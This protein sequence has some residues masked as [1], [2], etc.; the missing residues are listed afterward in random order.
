MSSEFLNRSVMFFIVFLLLFNEVQSF[1]Q[2]LY[3]PSDPIWLLDSTNFDQFIL[4]KDHFWVVE[5]YNKWCGH[6]IRF[7]PIWKEFSRS[8]KGWKK[9]VQV[10]AVDC[11]DDI[12]VQLCRNYKVTAYPTIKVFNI[13][14]KNGDP[15]YEIGIE[16]NVTFIKTE[17]INILTNL[18]NENIPS[19]WPSL[20]PVKAKTINQLWQQQPNS[21]TPI[22]L[23]VE[24]PTSTI[25]REIILD[26]SRNNISNVK[27]VLSNQT[28]VEELSHFITITS[29]PML[30]ML[31]NN[32]D[33][34]IFQS[35]NAKVNLREKFLRIL[36]PKL[37]HILP[38]ESTQNTLSS[39][40][41]NVEPSNNVYMVDLENA[42]NYSLRQEVGVHE[43]LKEEKLEALKNFIRILIKYFPGRLSIMRYLNKL[44]LWI[45]EQK[46]EIIVENMMENMILLQ[47]KK[48]YLPPRRDW[49]GCKGSKPSFRGYPCSLWMLFHTLT[50]QAYQ[51]Y[52]KGNENY[53]QEVL[54]AIRGYVK[55][56]FTCADCSEHFQQMASNLENE[57][58][59][60]EDTILWLWRAHNK[61]N[62]RLS[63]DIN[64]NDP[65][66]PKVQFPPLKL[67]P[68]C[69]DKTKQNEDSLQDEK[70][71]SWDILRTLN[72]LI[73]F[74]DKASIKQVK[75]TLHLPTRESRYPIPLKD[76]NALVIDRS[77]MIDS[78]KF[79]Y[80]SGMD[81]SLCV[82]LYIASATLMVILYFLFTLRKRKWKTQKR[83]FVMYP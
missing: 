27:R 47:T 72:F 22:M 45:L 21:T 39:M 12:N 13:Q 33:I 64:T 34:K 49:E 14:S 73:T 62:H 10:A 53:P 3:S 79:K 9:I 42:L 36:D 29:L 59:K 56:F 43:I 82:M 60:P 55:Y 58:Q 57:V 65:K 61:V 15:Q 23:I 69:H 32:V 77:K 19:S 1:G 50:V 37:S 18:W 80:F 8:I 66:H 83:S 54:F 26:L 67:C 5:F 75:T 76:S 52:Q 28:L 78:W 71:E 38:D 11:S 31:K 68:E 44:Y 40:D 35:D 25:G 7:A 6:C 51:K 24:A 81:I 46:N 2:P 30:L 63:S 74:Y 4:C 70:L 20:L 17:L 16:H 41:N 48:T